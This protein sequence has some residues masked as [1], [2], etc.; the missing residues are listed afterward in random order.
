MSVRKQDIIDHLNEL[1]NSNKWS[2]YVEILN[3]LDS[4]KDVHP[5]L[6]YPSSIL[7][8]EY[9]NIEKNDEAK[10]L[11]VKLAKTKK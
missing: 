3:S 1:A 5:Y 10:R 8:N 2:S 6:I 9:E 11:K 7:A 4:N